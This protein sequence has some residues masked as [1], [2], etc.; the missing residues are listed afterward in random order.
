MNG[1][2]SVLGCE[3]GMSISKN[4]EPFFAA[5]L[6]HSRHLVLDWLNG[7]CTVSC[8]TTEIGPTS[9]TCIPELKYRGCEP[10][11]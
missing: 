3:Q 10:R 2:F 9:R 6:H 5:L 4:Q 8:P 7:A 11:G 1:W